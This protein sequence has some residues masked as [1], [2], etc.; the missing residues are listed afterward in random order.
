MSSRWVVVV[1]SP[2]TGRTL[3]RDQVVRGDT[4]AAIE[5]AKRLAL[6]WVTDEEPTVKA[7]LRAVAPLPSVVVRVDLPPPQVAVSFNSEGSE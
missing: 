2:R 6:A 1:S 3:G 5:E 7:D 4:Q